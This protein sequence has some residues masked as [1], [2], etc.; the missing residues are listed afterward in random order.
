MIKPDYT[1][2]SFKVGIIILSIVSSVKA[3]EINESAHC[4]MVFTAHQAS[5]CGCA[6]P[7]LEAIVIGGSG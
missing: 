3:D 5:V 2:I 1:I 4:I 6:P 7:I